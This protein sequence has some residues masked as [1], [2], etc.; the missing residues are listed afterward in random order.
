[1][2]NNKHLK[3]SA[4]TGPANSINSVKKRIKKN[5]LGKTC[6]LI[7]GD[8]IKTVPD[9]LENYESEMM[10]SGMS[11]FA[12]LYID[13]NAYEPALK[14]K[15]AFRSHMSSGAIICIDEHVQGSE[16]KALFDFAHQQN[17]RVF[18]NGNLEVPMQLKFPS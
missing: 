4:F 6:T 8:A 11:K 9:F 7:Q 3:Q 16:T 1:M 17:L 18:R 10:Q 12:L 15:I 5:N 2:K 14:S 13:C